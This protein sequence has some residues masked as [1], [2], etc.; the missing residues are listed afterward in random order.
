M[1]ASTITGTHLR[2][3]ATRQHTLVPAT[4]AYNA[5]TL[6][7]DADAV[8]SRWPRAELYAATVT[9][10]SGGVKDA[11]GNALARRL[12]VWS[13]TTAAASAADRTGDDL[14]SVGE[15]RGIRH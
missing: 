1:N 3:S 7:G 15:A 14:E 9:G 5:S 13:F 11:A 2:A 6:V 4:V 12:S 10:G 8:G